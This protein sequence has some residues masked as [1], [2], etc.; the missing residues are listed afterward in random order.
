MCD[1]KVSFILLQVSSNRSLY[2]YST[3]LSYCGWK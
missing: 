2:R 1:A 3:Q